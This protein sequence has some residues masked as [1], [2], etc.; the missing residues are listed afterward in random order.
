MRNPK[1][2]A[3]DGLLHLSLESHALDRSAILPMKNNW[4]KVVHVACD[5]QN[6]STKSIV[7]PSNDDLKV[8]QDHPTSHGSAAVGTSHE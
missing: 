1:F 5:S 2:Q 8:Q 4:E 7:N 6:A 3:N